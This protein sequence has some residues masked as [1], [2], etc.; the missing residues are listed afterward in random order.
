MK[1]LLLTNDLYLAVGGGQTVYRTIIESAPDVDFYYFRH[2]ESEAN[3]Q[4]PA[5]A[6]TFTPI[7]N[8]AHQL[9]P[10][11]EPMYPGYCLNALNR[12]ADYAKSVAGQS[13]DI[14]ESPD[15]DVIGSFIRDVFKYYNVTIGRVV[16]AMHGNLSTSIQLNWN[17]SETISLEDL[18][19]RQFIAADGVYS[20]SPAYMKEWT[21]RFPRPITYIDPLHFVKRN[22]ID[23]VYVDDSHKKPDL[24]CVGRLEKRKGHDIFLELARWL[25][26]SSYGCPLLIGSNEYIPG[27]GLATDV[28][29]GQAVHR[30][31]SEIHH[32]GELTKGKLDAFY[33]GK[34]LAI[35][36]VRYDTLNLVALEALFQGCPTAVSGEAGVC[37]Y[38]DRQWPGLPYVK[39]DFSNLYSCVDA[40]Q[41]ILANYGQYRQKLH[42]YLHDNPVN[43]PPLNMRALYQAFLD[44]PEPV[45]IQ[46]PLLNRRY[47]RP[48]L[49]NLASRTIPQ[50]V[51]KIARR[52]NNKR[53]LLSAQLYRSLRSWVKFGRY[54]HYRYMDSVAANSRNMRWVAWRSE[55]SKAEMKDKLADFYRLCESAPIMRPLYWKEIARLEDLRSKPIFS[56]TYKLRVMR[57]LG[58]DRFGLLDS[59]QKS[60]EILG[61]TD[62][63]E[64]AK[65]M[66]GGNSGQA[67]KQVYAFLKAARA[68]NI[69]KPDLPYEILED[70]RDPTLAP[71]VSIIVSL[72][73]A[74]SK[75][76]FFLTALARQTLLKAGQVEIIIQ[77]SASPTDEKGELER[78]LKKT[79]LNLV[80]GRSPERETIQCAWNRGIKLARAPYLVFL[81]VDEGLYP[82]ALE[83]MA[84]ALDND[85][86]VDWVM[87]NS[88]IMDVDS[89]GVL[90]RDVMTYDR[91]DA[92]KDHVY[93]ETCYLSW[94]GGMYRKDIHDRCGYY[95]ETFRGAGD[96]E[97]KNRILPDINVKFI[98]ATLGI[99]FN[100]P[101]ERATAS[102]MAEIEDS[103]AWY[104]HR[105]LGGVRYAFENRPLEDLKKQLLRTLG[106]RK[107][108]CGH[109][110]TDFDYGM[111]LAEYGCERGGD[112]WWQAMRADLVRL[113]KILLTLE[114]GFKPGRLSL[115]QYK[116]LFKEALNLQRKHADMLGDNAQ[117]TYN[118]FNDNRYEQHSWLWRSI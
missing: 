75:L 78:F 50:P 68:K 67:D 32:L 42:D 16:L 49:R 38:L 27:W 98:P 10:V 45:L 34:N 19:R 108:Y 89:R 107:S 14:V 1:V 110:S 51:K 29:Y 66:Y 63:A 4:R 103:R 21:D 54:R 20:I 97:F 111:V 114:Y 69:S 33:K 96:T 82:E 30:D 8:I 91:T 41:N 118:L 85:S 24:C 105:T 46:Q 57:A 88:H 52:I 83:V 76:N 2:L 90:A 28:L 5:N 99:F 94:V 64:A 65:A 9:Y 70:R 72:Y 22:P 87:A 17:R 7:P 62:G 71:R 106:Y 112:D 116:G 11:T 56:A 48:F 15:Y 79:P 13:F 74:A 44:A 104:I 101:E 86:D 115:R 6:H 55:N 18:E 53:R 80:Y 117:P 35:L 12:L 23:S 73:N 39:I 84:S 31:M 77:D 100:Y 36:P 61:Y 58:D 113:R 25:P 47:W 81:G 93:L 109:L 92:T 40:L 26:K 60:L 43:L 59:C 3:K 37:E 95:D 102:P